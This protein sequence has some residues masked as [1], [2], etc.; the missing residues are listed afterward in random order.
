MKSGCWESDSEEGGYYYIC[1]IGI[2]IEAL[3]R[4]ELFSDKRIGAR[5][6][7][8]QW[9]SH[10]DALGF[11][12][13]PCT[14]REELW[15]IEINNVVTTGWR[16]GSIGGPNGEQPSGCVWTLWGPNK[17]HVKSLPIGSVVPEF[18]FALFL[19]VHSRRYW[20]NN[21]GRNFKIC[22]AAFG[23]PDGRRQ[24]RSSSQPGHCVTQ[25]AEIAEEKKHDF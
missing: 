20:D 13:M 12:K 23:V 4:N 5:W 9:E 22:L 1:T 14:Q 17:S 21:L 3:V 11:I 10:H 18:E 15:R 24:Q 19:E 6:S 7:I 25:G 16:N 8:D 2:W